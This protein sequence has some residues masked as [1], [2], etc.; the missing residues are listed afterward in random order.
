MENNLNL[1]KYI[2]YFLITLI[3]ALCLYLTLLFFD[4]FLMGK[5]VHDRSVVK[6][7]NIIGKNKSEAI[8][9]L[10]DLQLEPRIKNEQYS[11]AMPSGVII[12]QSPSPNSE[13]KIGRPIYIIVSKGRETVIV[14]Y[15]TGMTI[16]DAKN[17]ITKQGLVLGNI[18]YQRNEF[19][20]K[21]T[22]FSQ[23]YGAGARV[24]YGTTLNI[25]VSR[26][27]EAMVAVPVLIGQKYEEIENILK[28]NNLVLGNVTYRSSETF[29]SNTIIEQTPAQ[30][31]SVYSGTPISI[32][33]AQ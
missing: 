23:T 25:V 20:G 21:D 30:F 17:T 16:T 13:V 18:F 5:L 3:F 7:P 31:E 32:V 29:T 4:G 24:P 22:V 33:V 14:P 9:S 8:S 15:L 11:E 10:K 1:T 27:N 12:S 19:Y 28:A 6:I 2:P 26:G